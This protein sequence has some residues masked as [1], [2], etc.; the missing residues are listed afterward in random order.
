MVEATVARS[1]S[2]AT[3]RPSGHQQASVLDP[4]VV[5]AE[6]T[7]DEV[8]QRRE[9]RLNSRVIRICKDRVHVDRRKRRPAGH[10]LRTGRDRPAVKPAALPVSSTKAMARPT[11]RYAAPLRRA[12]AQVDVL[13]RDQAKGAGAGGRVPDPPR[14]EPVPVGRS[15]VQ[16]LAGKVE[17]ALRQ[18]ALRAGQAEHGIE[19]VDPFRHR[20]ARR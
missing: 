18:R 2:T 1:F 9:T 14:P 19:A 6:Q 11:V 4:Q 12:R 17:G 15:E 5:D 20:L 13:G 7:A 16:K 3:A 10:R 8:G